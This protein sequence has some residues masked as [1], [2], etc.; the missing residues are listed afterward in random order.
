M[1]HIDKPT[2]NVK[3]V[4]EACISNYEDVNFKKRL[5]SVTAF[6][7]TSATNYDSQAGV[8]NL[9]AISMVNNVNNIITVDEM[10]KVY[11]HKLVRKGQPGRMYY[12]KLR[13]SAKNNIC[14]LCNQRT[15]T[16]LDHVLPKTF[17]PIFAVTPFNLIPACAD[18]NKIKDRY[19][20]NIAEEEIIHPYY[21]DISNQQYLYAV[22]VQTTPPSINFYIKQSNPINIIEKRLNK[23][24]SLFALNELYT[25]NAAGEL[26]NISFRLSK[27][28]ST[29]GRECVREYLREEFESRYENNRNSWQTAMYKALYKNAWFC[30]GGFRID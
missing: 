13:L 10:K 3:D 27:L 16:T 21:D 4:F 14:P 25:S 22:L 30:N 6:I 24:F 19:Q 29:G 9:N 28:Y 5:N 7:E 23:H 1:V 17:Y 11:D 8:N 15:V 20:P 2:D 12:E 18:C 26:A